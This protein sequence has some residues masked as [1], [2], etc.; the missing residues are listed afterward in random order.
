MSYY[1]DD[2]RVVFCLFDGF[3]DAFITASSGRLSIDEL[4]WIEREFKEGDE[5]DD[6]KHFC[7]VEYKVKFQPASDCTAGYWEFDL[8]GRHE[9][10]AVVEEEWNPAVG[11]EV[12]NLLHP[13]LPRRL[14]LLEAQ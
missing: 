1:G 9:T 5:D 8:T 4:Q 12:T 2:T 10:W 11:Y 13:L 6:L 7:T 14:R 3:E